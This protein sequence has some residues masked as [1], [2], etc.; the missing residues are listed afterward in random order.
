M[1]VGI[2]SAPLYSIFD[3]TQKGV[4]IRKDLRGANPLLFSVKNVVDGERKVRM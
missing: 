1:Y 2:S 4:A 3:M